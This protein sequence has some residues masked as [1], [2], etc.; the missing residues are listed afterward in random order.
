NNFS[1]FPKG[2]STK[3]LQNYRGFYGVFQFDTTFSAPFTSLSTVSTP[4]KHQASTVLLAVLFVWP[5]ILPY[6][7]LMP[8]ILNL[9]NTAN[10]WARDHLE[11]RDLNARRRYCTLLLP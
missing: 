10:R 11:I 3:Y 1:I 9:C 6:L 8:L 7:F 5:F 4:Q 2:S